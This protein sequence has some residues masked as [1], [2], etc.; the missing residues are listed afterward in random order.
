MAKD[1]PECE[2]ARV[3]SDGE[4]QQR[5]GLGKTHND[6]SCVSVHIS[7]VTSAVRGCARTKLLMHLA[8]GKVDSSLIE[9]SSLR[10][11][12]RSVLADLER[13]VT[14]LHSSAEQKGMLRRGCLLRYLGRLSRLC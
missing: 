7:D 13:L 9:E 6:K 4:N 10:D 14:A 8:L 5:L 2:A 11:L 1:C 3:E 12:E